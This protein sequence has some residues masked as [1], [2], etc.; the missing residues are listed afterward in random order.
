MLCKGSCENA[1]WFL[2]LYLNT[3]SGSLSKT[4]WTLQFTL[5]TG[6]I[7]LPSVKSGKREDLNGD[8]FLSLN[9]ESRSDLQKFLPSHPECFVF[10][11]KWILGVG[12]FFFP[13]LCV[14]PLIYSLT[15][16][17][18][19]NGW[20]SLCVHRLSCL[21]VTSRDSPTVLSAFLQAALFIKCLK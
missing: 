18:G 11:R 21:I 13:F 12:N 19:G 14:L 2:A 6:C 16:E 17:A 8:I 7:H 5:N 4:S 1:V 3:W 9:S 15:L 10:P 20:I